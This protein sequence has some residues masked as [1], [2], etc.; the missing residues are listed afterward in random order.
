[1][2]TPTTDTNDGT[3]RF[4]NVLKTLNL[5]D[6][7]RQAQ[8]NW[9]N[10][11]VTNIEM[12]GDSIIQRKMGTIAAIT[13][14]G[15]TRAAIAII[16]KWIVHRIAEKK[17][18]SLIVVAPTVR[19][20]HQWHGLLNAHGFDNVG[21][22]GDGHKDITAKVLVC[23]INSAVKLRRSN[24]GCLIVVDECHR[25]ATDKNS[26][27]FL[28]NKHAAVLG[29]SATPERADGLN[30]LKWT[31]KVV[32]KLGYTQ[33]IEQGVIPNFEVQ[34]IATPLN[35][36][37]R[38]QYDEL[39]TRISKIY[40]MIEKEFGH[41]VNPATL[42]A[43]DLK[44][45]WS[46]LT[47]QRKD[48]CNYSAARTPLLHFLLDKHRGQKIAVF[49]EGIHQLEA[50][51]QQARGDDFQ[52]YVA[53]SQKPNG[54]QEFEAWKA[55]HDCSHG[56]LF[57]V[58][59]LKEGIDVPDMDVMIM[60]S[61]TNDGRSRV[62]TVG[63]ALRGKA[64]KIYLAYT[65]NTTDSAGWQNMMGTGDIP[66]Q[67]VTHWHYVE[68]AGLGVKGSLMP[69]HDKIPSMV[70]DGK[71]HICQNCGKKFY[72]EWKAIVGNHECLNITAALDSLLVEFSDVVESPTDFFALDDDTPTIE[73]YT[74]EWGE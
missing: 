72:T 73:E 57:S 54:Y 14:A 26:A 51:A 46:A 74:G 7:Q 34:T 44:N 55:N 39:T 70:P 30:V 21:R 33:A 2:M 11:P 40:G 32:Y 63:R 18:W 37:E 68:V 56:V 19:L 52:V 3:I 16:V 67:N 41:G 31:G 10:A 48:V 9:W 22:Y 64:A 4:M 49:H 45:A 65:P 1:M 8:A 42:H 24:D 15:K 20:M 53:H 60:L 71:D 43:C 61:V 66:E 69:R 38:N 36:M 25:M 5:Y 13:G 62:Q 29:L 58:K 59:A 23:T 12:S 27:L 35:H 28:H 47:N 17:M 50:L 6:W